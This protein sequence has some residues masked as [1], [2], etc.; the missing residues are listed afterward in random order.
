MLVLTW[1]HCCVLCV[2]SLCTLIKQLDQWRFFRSESSNSSKHTF[3]FGK[4]DCT[5]VWESMTI[6]LS[7]RQRSVI[8]TVVSRDDCVALLD[9]ESPSK[10]I[11]LGKLTFSLPESTESLP[12]LPFSSHSS[13]ILSRSDVVN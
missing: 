9:A 5:A 11:W 4:G 2:C 6:K 13:S 8:C 3:E 7:S 10:N 1:C 12:L